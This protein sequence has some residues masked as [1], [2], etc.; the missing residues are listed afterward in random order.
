MNEDDAIRIRAWYQSLLAWHAR[1]VEWYGA[2]SE[3]TATYGYAKSP[4]VGPEPLLM[5]DG[6][7]AMATDPREFP[8]RPQGARDPHAP[9]HH[10]VTAGAGC[11]HVTR[12]PGQRLPQEASAPAYHRATGDMAV[13]EI[14]APV[15]TQS[16]EVSQ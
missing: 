9:G 14:L 1:S 16:P 7:P 8:T 6:P 13:A 10:L 2:A 3:W 12:P 5:A 11:S 15:T 4:P